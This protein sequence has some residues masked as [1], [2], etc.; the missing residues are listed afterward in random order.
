MAS[1]DGLSMAPGMT[2]QTLK[3]KITISTFLYSFDWY[4]DIPYKFSREVHSLRAGS[5]VC[6]LVRVD[7]RRSRNLQAG[8]NT[9]T[10]PQTREPASRLRGTPN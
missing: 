10:I 3:K 7:L 5:L 8:R 1:H 6:G 9:C 2:R 4:L